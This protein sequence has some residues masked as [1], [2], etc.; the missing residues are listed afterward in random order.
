MA[1]NPEVCM[2]DLFS[3]SISFSSGPDHKDSI[4]WVKERYNGLVL[5]VLTCS[6][7]SPSEMETCVKKLQTFGV[8]VSLEQC[9]TLI[10]STVL[11]PDIKRYLFFNSRGFGLALAVIFYMCIWANIYSI[12]RMFAIG[13]Q[14][15]SII[16]VSLIAAA[17]TTITILIIDHRQREINV[18]TDV[19]LAAANDSFLKHHVLIGVTNDMRSY[20]NTLKLWFV[21]F[22]PRRCLQTLSQRLADMKRERTP[23]LRRCL[24]HLCIAMETAIDPGPGTDGSNGEAEGAARGHS[25]E[26]PLLSVGRASQKKPLLCSEMVP[27]IQE[28]EPD[29]MAHQ[30]LIIFSACYVRLLI[31]GQLTEVSVVRHAEKINAP[32]LCQFIEASALE[33]EQCWSNPR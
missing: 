7:G 22:D 23:A 14:W 8:Q 15:W 4:R 19:R 20:R 2:E 16:L 3:C 5:S 25:E 17:I 29:V 31:T 27:L 1:S 13:Q 24:D 9:R 30:L 28:G 12:V 10:Q 26:S 32:C 21:H 6:S 18:N 33:G 11:Q